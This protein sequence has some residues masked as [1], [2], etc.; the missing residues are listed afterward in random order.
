VVV[1][2]V[3]N[4]RACT[5]KVTRP[6]RVARQTPAT[7]PADDAGHAPVSVDD[8]RV[9]RPQILV[10]G[11]GA[12]GLASALA[13]RRAG[14]DVVLLDER[15]TAGGQYYK[16]AAVGEPGGALDAQQAAGQR[17]VEAVARSGAIVVPECEVWGAFPADDAAADIF[18]VDPGGARRFHPARLVVATGAYERALPV[19][20]WT[21]PGVMTTGAAQ[22]LWR[23]Y[24]T[25]P[26]R[27]ILIA[28]NGPLNLQV[29]CEFA[30]AGAT[31]VAVAETARAPRAGALGPLLAM[32]AADPDLMWAG[33][34][35]RA[36]LARHRVPLLYGRV[37]TRIERQASG[38]T[39]TLG[40]LAGR[41]IEADRRLET[42]VVCLGYGFLPANEILRALEAAHDYDRARGQLVTRRRADGETT[43]AGV[44]GVGDC[45]GLGGAKAAVE[46]G[47]LAGLAAARSLGL[48]GSPVAA[49]ES[50]ARRRLARSRRFEHALWTLFAVPRFDHELAD[51]ETL[52]CRCEEV[53]LGRL[54]ATLADGRPSIGEVKLRT[55]AGMGRCQGR[56][57]APVLASLLAARHGRPIDEMAFFAPRAPVKPVAIADLAR[58]A[59]PM[60]RP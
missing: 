25:L 23:S 2:G 8:Y 37:V 60:A 47:T 9:E 45:C 33:L 17:L 55:R 4:Q 30:R 53:S 26:G 49:L 43:V 11:G 51:A 59:P 52:V 35:Y 1:D 44:Y 36:G 27:R 57:C 20:G 32:A 16:Q 19:P 31:V 24:Q 54:E 39:V 7:L 48:T 42:D 28:G 29:A 50:A 38:L 58:L 46:E 10:I 34:A 15:G 5:L 3:P 18:A 22:T 13:A 6:L 12:G 21:L 14:A 40:H 41:S 56:Y